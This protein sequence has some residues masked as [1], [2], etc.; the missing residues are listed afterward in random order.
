M[1]VIIRKWTCIESNIW[2]IDEYGFS[3][4]SAWMNDNYGWINDDNINGCNEKNIRYKERN[5][6]KKDLLA[7]DMI[8]IK[9][10]IEWGKFMR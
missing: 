5:D 8:I 9:Y 4:I 2:V 6:W 7:I 10:I 3:V 1:Y